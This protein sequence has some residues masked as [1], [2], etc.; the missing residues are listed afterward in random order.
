M[1]ACQRYQTCNGNVERCWSDIKFQNP[2]SSQ[3]I[4]RR[5][6][7][8]VF[9]FHARRISPPRPRKTKL[10]PCSLETSLQAIYNAPKM[11]ACQRYQTCNANIERRWS[12]IKIQDP[13]SS[14]KILREGL[15]WY[16]PSMPVEFHHLGPGKTKLDPCSLETSLQAIYTAPK[17]EACQRYQTCNGNVER[18]W[19]D[20]KFQNPSSPQKILR[21]GSEM[22]FPFHAR[23]ISPPRPRENQI[24][25]M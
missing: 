6:S 4:L 14:Q 22:V 25:P 5:G 10:D 11:A 1:E 16:S 9:P 21:R 3:K 7:E 15:K 19:S 23:R 17:M 2:S 24:R 20:I 8:M 13:S 18:R 12:D